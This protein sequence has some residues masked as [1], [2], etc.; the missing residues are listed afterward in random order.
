VAAGGW[1]ADSAASAIGIWRITRLIDAPS[2][3]RIS[4]YTMIRTMGLPANISTN[5]KVPL[6]I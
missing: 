5:G 3:A 1:H 6:D 4:Q 2:D